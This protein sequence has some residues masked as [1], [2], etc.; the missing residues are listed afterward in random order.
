[1]I[2]GVNALVGANP[3]RIVNAARLSL[4]SVA[5]DNDQLCGGGQALS[6]I[7]EYLESL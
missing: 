5:R 1:M 3:E 4:G 2:Y 6:N 7:A